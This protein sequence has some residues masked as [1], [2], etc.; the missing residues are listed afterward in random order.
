MN[1]NFDIQHTPVRRR[2]F[3]LRLSD[4]LYDQRVALSQAYHRSM[5][6]RINP[7]IDYALEHLQQEED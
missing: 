5:N 4:A 3:S 2:A 7:C 6:K 1:H